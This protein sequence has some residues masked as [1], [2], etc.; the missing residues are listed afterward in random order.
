MVFVNLYNPAFDVTK[1]T[2]INPNGTKYYVREMHSSDGEVFW[3]DNWNNSLF[4]KDNVISQFKRAAEEATSFIYDGIEYDGFGNIISKQE[5]QYSTSVLV[6]SATQEKPNNWLYWI[7][8]GI[9]VL[10]LLKSE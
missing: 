6:N 7:L 2:F 5:S 4:T 1:I 8:G 3:I 9:A 10:L